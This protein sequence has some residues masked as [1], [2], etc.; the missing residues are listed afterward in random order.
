MK[1]CAG[2]ACDGTKSGGPAPLP[3]NPMCS[4]LT[5]GIEGTDLNTLMQKLCDGFKEKPPTTEIAAASSRLDAQ[6]ASVAKTAT[7]NPTLQ[8]TNFAPVPTAPA[9]AVGVLGA[10]ALAA[11]AL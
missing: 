8:S 2:K 4:R 5:D 7:S 9:A 3:L 6:Y 1:I 11:L 10:V